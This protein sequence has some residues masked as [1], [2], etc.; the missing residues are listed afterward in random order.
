M[1]LF[2]RMLLLTIV[3][4]YAVRLIIK[5]MGMEDYG[6][7]NAVAGVVTATNVFCGVLALSIQRFFSYALGTHNTKQLNEIFSCS[8][9][10]ILVL[11]VLTIAFLESIGL[12]FVHNQLTIPAERMQA[13]LW[14][15]QF[16][17]FTLVCSF[18]QT[19]Y[20]A[21]MFAHEDMGTYT[22]IST[23]ECLLKF[24]AAYL[25]GL[26]CFDHLEF[27]SLGL[28]LCAVIVL[29]LYV[30]TAKWRYKECH[31]RMCYN[32]ELYKKILSFSG[33]TLFG[34]IAGTAMLQGNTILLNMF[35]GTIA[36]AAFGIALQINNAFNSLTSNMVLAF[37]PPMIKLFAERQFDRLDNLFCIG[38]KCIS[39]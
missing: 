39:D 30:F 38:N 6:I 27:Y 22:L 20:T 16:A 29:L 11:S 19:P 13:A 34:S 35:F 1:V 37:R 36:T 4:L 8:I 7:F 5:G 25:I 24:L 14:I 31:Y 32:K 15:F 21:A 12:W 9:N 10:I 26:V 3:N 2:L 33:W 23:V 28:L 17:I 18:L